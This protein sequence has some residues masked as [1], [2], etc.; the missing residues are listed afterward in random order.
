MFAR[1]DYD[2]KPVQKEALWK[3]LI[4]EDSRWA[5][6]KV[7]SYKAQLEKVYKNLGMYKKWSKVLKEKLEKDFSEDV[8]LAKMSEALT[9]KQE[10]ETNN[11]ID[12]MFASLAGE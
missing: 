1:V 12:D 3:D 7:L 5:F 9:L 11:E 4:M 8:V 6:P 2:L 10:E